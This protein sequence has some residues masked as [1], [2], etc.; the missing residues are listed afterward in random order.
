MIG[1]AS[2]CTMPL[3]GE[4]QEEDRKLISELMVEKMDRH[5]TSLRW[6]L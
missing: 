5:L 3:I 4:S 6:A 1:Q 2:D